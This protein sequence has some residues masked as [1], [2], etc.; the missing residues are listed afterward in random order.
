MYIVALL[1]MHLK[2]VPGCYFYGLS[3]EKIYFFWNMGQYWSFIQVILKLLLDILIKWAQK[4]DLLVG[5]PSKK[6]V[7][8]SGSTNRKCFTIR[9]LVSA[10]RNWPGWWNNIR[11]NTMS[12]KVSTKMLEFVV[13]IFRRKLWQLECNIFFNLF[14]RATGLLLSFLWLY[15]RLYHIFHMFIQAIHALTKKARLSSRARH[16][17]FVFQLL[18]LCRALSR[19]SMFSY[20]HSY[21]HSSCTCSSFRCG[22]W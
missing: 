18:A 15:I 16:N 11:S 19:Q 12:Y 14:R 21:S 7:G 5:C 1:R 22:S 2:L 20:T 6:G 17:V 13:S 10:P 9:T 4:N 8:A 3:G